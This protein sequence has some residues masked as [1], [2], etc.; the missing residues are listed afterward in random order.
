MPCIE[1]LFLLVLCVFGI[2]FRLQ[3]RESVNV[4]LFLSFLLVNQ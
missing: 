3:P 1:V 4:G 2:P